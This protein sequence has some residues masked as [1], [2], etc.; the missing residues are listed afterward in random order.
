MLE[1]EA[2]G[3]GRDRVP[4]PGAGA[5]APGAAI[6]G[7]WERL[8]AV[9]EPD[10]QVRSD[11]LTVLENTLV[12]PRERPRDLARFTRPA[13]PTPPRPTAAHPRAWK[14][15]L[16]RPPK[17]AHPACGDLRPW[18]CDAKNI[19]AILEALGLD[20]GAHP[21]LVRHHGVP[22]VDEW[23][24]LPDRFV[25]D[26]LPAL[27]GVAWVEVRAV[28]GHF[29][30]L[31]LEH[32]EILRATVA[33]VLLEADHGHASTW[34]ERL[35]ARPPERRL[36][37]VRQVLV[38]AMRSGVGPL[39]DDEPSPAHALEPLDEELL[40][41]ADEMAPDKYERALDFLILNRDA[42]THFLVE[43]LGLVR[44]FGGWPS[45]VRLGDCAD[46]PS[47][48]IEALADWLVE[49]GVEHVDS[50]VG[51]LV[52]AC[53]QLEGFAPLLARTDWR[54][55]GQAVAREWLDT[56]TGH[57]WDPVP[58]VLARWTIVRE[59]HGEIE[60]ALDRVP[61][62]HRVRFLD[63]IGCFIAW[64]DADELARRSPSAAMAL[65]RRVAHPPFPRESQMWEPVQIL[66]DVDPRFLEIS[67]RA[68][69]HL[70]REGRRDNE[71]W[72][73]G[74]GLR[75]LLRDAADLAWRA[76]EAYPHRLLSLARLL[77]SFSSPQRRDLVR[78]AL[79]HPIMATS[80][81]GPLVDWIEKRLP[82]DVPSPVTRK[83]AQ[84]EDGTR[85]LGPVASGKARQ[86][87]LQRLVLARLGVV[88][89]VA[90]AALA[91]GVN[92]SAEDE[93][94]LH[95]L[96]L[97]RL[98]SLN[99]RPLRTLLKAVSAGD[100][101]YV[102]TH[103]ETQRWLRCHPDLDVQVWRH[104]AT[105]TFEHER[106]GTI[107]LSLEQ[108]PLEVL[109]LG[110]YVGTC[111]SLGGCCA[112]AAAA[113]LLDA[114]KRVVYARDTHGTVR[115]RQLLALADD[116]RLVCFPVYPQSADAS[117]RRAFREYD[118][119]FAEALRVEPCADRDEYTVAM[120]LSRDWWDDR[121]WESAPRARLLSAR[122]E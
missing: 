51:S 65:A 105:S 27:R 116:G 12:C 41:A 36:A 10:A 71:S 7:A 49:N 26:L 53:G 23:N 109:R 62:S 82:G 91:Q 104:G 90:K 37:L 38:R 101:D 57:L 50:L 40:A 18:L 33:R 75:T 114:N 88:E 35:V 44:R 118:A 113:A 79:Q 102:W 16:S 74:R 78:L 85:L 107:T 81:E 89:G 97:L 28:L 20:G 106:H 100:A 55:H 61:D 70:V 58:L 119:T 9:R 72:L 60:Q 66:L 84:H 45:C 95:A 31:A 112:E 117:L 92:L 103:P 56:Y 122:G 120:I 108:Q 6:V 19:P 5:T 32:D 11:V 4:L 96:R 22:R 21:Y 68:V 111:L 15:T 46:F 17:A 63:T 43:G 98:V 83:L 25:E 52:R 87:V 115:A 93:A 59:L 94:S 86:D 3:P 64:A 8:G 1:W 54:R 110:T 39:E 76:F 67:D 34:L 48:R 30:S 29:H 24:S 99:R 73:L 47:A 69:L 121:V 77:G 14:G 2:A 42:S 13:A 80:P